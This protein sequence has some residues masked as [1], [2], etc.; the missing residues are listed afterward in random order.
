MN[1]IE[2]KKC[3]GEIIDA[4]YDRGG[5]D[6]WWSN[7]DNETEKEIIA[8]LENIVEKRFNKIIDNFGNLE[9]RFKR[10]MNMVV[11]PLDNED[12]IQKILTAHMVPKKYFGTEEEGKMITNWLDKHGDPKIEKQVELQAA[13][14][15]WLFEHDEHDNELS[16]IKGAEWQQGQDKKLYSE[17]EVKE[18]IKLS[19]EEGM[20][21]QR[22]IN[23]KVKIPYMR[24]KDFTIR[25]FEQFKKK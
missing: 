12:P 17:E 4:L 25:M 9:E 2:I 16:F 19:C 21:I 18:I 24:I 6:D 8:L 14:L 7:I 10:D 23:D 1:K 22:T 13:A 5:F 11:M 20:L 15:E 3:V